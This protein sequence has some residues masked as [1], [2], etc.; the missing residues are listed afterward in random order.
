MPPLGL[1]PGLSE[2]SPL[3]RLLAEVGELID[4]GRFGEAI[5]LMAEAAALQPNHGRL[6][7]DLGGLYVETGRYAEAL[8]PLRRALE[9]NPRIAVA[10]WRLGVALH[11]LGDAGGAVSALE[12]AVEIR[13]DLSDAHFRLAVLYRD[14]GRRRDSIAFF[15][16]AAQLASEPGEQMLLEAEALIAEAR[17]PE[18]ES[19]LLS[20]L[21]LQPDL[22]TAHGALAKILTSAGRFQEAGRHYLAQLDRTP[23]AGMCYYE[24]VRSR[25]ITA[26]D[27]GILRR[28]DIAL[29]E[30]NPDDNNRAIM[31]L[32]RGKVLDDLG[33]YEEAMV[34]LDAASELRARAFAIDV[35]KFERQVDTIVELFSDE[36]IARCNSSNPDR[37]PVLILGLPRS[38]TTLVEQ[39]VS[40]HPD[41]VAGG[42][43]SYWRKRLDA[44]L[45]SGPDT[46][47][48]RFLAQAASEYLDLL[49]RISGTAPRVTDKDPFNF[50]AIGLV[51]MA[52]PRA[53]IIHCGRNLLDTALSI[54]HIHFSRSTAL[55]TGGKELVRYIRAFQR[56]MAHWHRVLP[57]GRLHEVEYE[58]LTEWPREE[59]PRLID[60][61][62]LAWNDACLSPHVNTRMV[63]TPS[64]W[65]VRQLINTGAVGRWRLFEPWLGPLAALMEEKDGGTA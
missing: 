63:D 48:E 3:G 42:E 13:P 25:R 2:S 62:G 26:D 30:Q 16:R 10:H 5:P 52:L 28:I 32:A 9:I 49:R 8:A 38:G 36:R 50:L 47:D 65:Q 24:Y 61:L 35:R 43:L 22:P 59:I 57:T 37:T 1:P 64:G 60:R 58:R 20:A 18:A 11:G 21:A 7:A 29:K 45:E 19:L 41:A 54:H 6:H 51:H 23:A 12:K 56:L 44:V 31:L 55:P 53:A 4:Q 33:R 46:L 14:Q 34:A 40:S 17:E 39:I 15:R 27:S